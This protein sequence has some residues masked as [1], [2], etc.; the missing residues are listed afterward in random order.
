[1]SLTRPLNL[2]KS[3][4]CPSFEDIK[5]QEAI[6]CKG[7]YQW[8]CS[9]YIHFPLASVFEEFEYIPSTTPG[10]LLFAFI[11]V[12]PENQFSLETC[13]TCVILCSKYQVL[14]FW[15][16]RC[17]LCKS[18]KSMLNSAFFVCFSFKWEARYDFH[19]CASS[20]E[21]AQGGNYPSF[22]QGLETGVNS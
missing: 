20:T 15:G 5:K 9:F 8:F 6:P 4:K 19:V 17:K 18:I 12:Q 3:Q 16:K 13:L 2:S 7:H 1:M 21:L 22:A 14:L 10:I 11:C